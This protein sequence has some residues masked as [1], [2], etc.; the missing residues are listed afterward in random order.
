MTKALNIVMDEA[1]HA[2]L[3]E[4]ADKLGISVEELAR[5]AVLDLVGHCDTTFQEAARRVLAKNAELY[6]RLS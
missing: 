3:R 1:E 5:A 6:E 2:A 4:K